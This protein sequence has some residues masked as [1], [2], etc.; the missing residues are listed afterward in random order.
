MSRIF[1]FSSEKSTSAILTKL[2]KTEGYKVVV[3]DD[4]AK[5]KDALKSEQFNLMITTVGKGG[6]ADSAVNM[7]GNCHTQYSS[8]PVIAITEAN[9]EAT[10]SR[11]AELK[12]FSCIEKP[13]K[14]DKLIAAVQKAVDTNDAM[15]AGNVN[16]DLQLEA[17][18]QFDNIVAESPAMKGVCDMISRVAGTDVTILVSG[19]KGTGKDLIAR[20]VHYNS[21][22]KENAIVAVDCSAPDAESQLFAGG[23]I[24]KASGGTL[25][26]QDVNKLVQSAQ[27][28]LLQC[29]QERKITKPGAKQP[30][31]I[32]VRLVA[33][34]GSN[35]QQ[36]VN[37]GKFLPDLYKF[38]KVIFLQIPP[39]NE[40]KQDIM[41]VIRQVLRK[42]VGEGKVMPVMES[43]VTDILQKYSWPGN[44]S[45]VESVLE[46]ILKTAKDGKITKDCL[47]PEVL[48]G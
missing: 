9:D 39:L 30:L 37:D 17:C 22:R 21:R 10:A 45:E 42:K 5:A 43:E 20:T 15:L 38:L 12:L 18:Y 24:E 29:L 2:L 40:R 27:R 23:L 25:F 47:P 3:A 44:V 16:M 4:T 11:L 32:D 8:M 7:I 26:L 6:E 28:P 13:L 33:S 34:T 36:L 46:H 1:L 48:K 14:V 19:E 41:P 31:A 35:L